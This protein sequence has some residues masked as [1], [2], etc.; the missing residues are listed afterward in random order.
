MR[1]LIDDAIELYIDRP[2]IAE[3]VYWVASLPDTERIALVLAYNVL[4]EKKGKF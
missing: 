2:E 4:K 3:L 1:E